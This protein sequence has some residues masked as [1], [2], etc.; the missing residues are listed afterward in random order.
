[1]KCRQFES[2]VRIFA[3]R[4]T[5]QAHS[6]MAWEALRHSEHCARCAERLAEER[7][8]ST[9]LAQF[10]R[11]TAC[12]AAPPRLEAALRT[13]FRQ[14][15]QSSGRRM[16][17]S[18]PAPSQR[19]RLGWTAA[20]AAAVLAAFATSLTWRTPPPV[21]PSGHPPAP[22]AE[23]VPVQPEARATR[24]VAQ[25][26]SAPE[27]PAHPATVVSPPRAQDSVGSP[28]DAPS[29]F[30]PLLYGGDPML[31]QTAVVRVELSGAMLQSLGF[32]LPGEPSARRVQADLMLGEDGVARAIRFV[33]ASGSSFAGQSF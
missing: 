3:N 23:A 12:S 24:H 7:K 17:I 20:V 1:M 19:R 9:E 26:V 29:D 6:G 8:L 18:V 4:P 32:P 14:H 13:A 5:S 27:S 11:S 28:Y 2:M 21:P 31:T 16:R 10:A 22:L 30:V 25:E 33:P 15:W